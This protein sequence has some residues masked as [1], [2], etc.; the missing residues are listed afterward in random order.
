[1]HYPFP[2]SLS[3]STYI[4]L[5]LPLPLASIITLRPC[6]RSQ[7]RPD[8]FLR[9]LKSEVPGRKIKNRRDFVSRARDL[10]LTVQDSGGEEEAA[11]EGKENA[12]QEKEM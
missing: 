8:K 12:T 1:M 3:L 9:R 7:Q 11:E 5:F 4:L 2:N 6:K 10:V